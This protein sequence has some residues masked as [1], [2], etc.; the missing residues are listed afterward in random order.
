VGGGDQ[1]KFFHFQQIQKSFTNEQGDKVRVI[2]N[3]TFS[4][5]AGKITS[6]V[7]PSGCG[8][9]TFLRIIAGFEANYSGK[10]TI[11]D[12]GIQETTLP[13]GAIGYIPQEPSLFPWY[14]VEEN[15]AFSLRLQNVPKLDRQRRVG[16]LLQMV[17]LEQ[18]RAY[19]PKELSG[20]MKQKVTI[21]R[22][23]ASPPKYRLLLLDE[24][25][26]ALDAQT[27]NALQRDLVAI[28]QSQNLTLIFV[29]HNIDEAVFISDQVVIFYEL[30][31]RVKTIMTV[32]LSH[33]RDRTSPEFIAIRKEVL[34]QWEFAR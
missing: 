27:R 34:K 12:G 17:N 26:S 14:T 29:T 23:L 20:G 24:P 19:Y 1:V 13:V 22:A 5:P 3:V 18:Y 33:P 15:V 16:E 31:A 21:C 6:I 7:G 28:Q 30:P 25:F 2:E 10:V 9:T 8:K 11:E 32:P 4:V